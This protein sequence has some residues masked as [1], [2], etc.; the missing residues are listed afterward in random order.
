MRALFSDFL[1]RGT[2]PF[3]TLT[4]LAGMLIFL[5]GG[6]RWF[7]YPPVSLT[8]D[9]KTRELHPRVRTVAELLQGEHVVLGPDDFCTPPPPAILARNAAVKV[10]RVIHVRKMETLST[11]LIVTWQ[12]RTRQNLRKMWVQRG[13]RREERERVDHTLYDGAE[14]KQKVLWHKKKTIPFYTLTLFSGKTGLPV[15]T[16][17]LLKARRFHML[18][19]GYYVGDPMVPGDTTYLGY[20]LQRGLVAVDPTVIPLKSR[21]YIP[22]YGYAYAADTGSAIKERRIDLAVSGRAEEA[23]FN[24]MN[25]TVYVL[26]KA[27]NW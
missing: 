18:A 8:V 16:Y 2:R 12:Q 3:L 20:K 27:N 26:E 14:V 21:L 7:R 9:G 1:K 19:T 22:R 4:A 25:V 24:H 11:P 5:V 13:Y 15:K 10:T 6:F 23:I 17:N